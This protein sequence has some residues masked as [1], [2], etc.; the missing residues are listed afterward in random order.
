[1]D[2]YDITD[3]TAV[4][5]R[6]QEML[7][8]EM[9]SC[10]IQSEARGGRAALMP[11]GVWDEATRDAA[12]AYQAAAGLPVTGELNEATWS[13]LA[14]DY[15]RILAENARPGS[16]SPFPYI[17]G[18]RIAEGERS[19]LVMILQIM[20]NTIS[21]VYDELRGIPIT[22][23]YDAATAEGI[24]RFQYRNFIAVTDFVDR[25]TWD[26]LARQYDIYSRSGAAGQ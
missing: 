26:A 1:M 5:G 6:F 14:R 3:E 15:K 17:R 16:I 24:R 23:V 22:G 7:S 19:D 25:T 10:V 8:Q 21:V 9:L 11:T 18:Y 13:A 2:F 20:M 4:I 12:A